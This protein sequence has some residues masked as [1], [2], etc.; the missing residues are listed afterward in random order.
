MSDDDI[1]KAFRERLMNTLRATAPV[2]SEDGVMVAGSEVPN[3]ISVDRTILVV[4]QDVDIAVP[5]SR[6]ARVKHRIREITGFTRSTEEPTVLVPNSDDYIEVNFIGIGDDRTDDAATYVFEDDEFPL[7]V[8]ANLSHLRPGPPVDI[9]GF[10]VPVPRT[11]GLL[12][13]KLLTDRSGEKGDRDLL[14]AL[15]LLILSRTADIDEFV[16][17]YLGCAD[18]ERYSVRSG[19]AALSLIEPRIHMPDPEPYRARIAELLTRLE[20]VEDTP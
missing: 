19:L 8:F 12:I 15:A 7:L 18:E 6:H 11:S 20:R 2:L 10:E 9:G 3:I 4:S 17:E 16:D 13:E 5:V 14:V 1:Y